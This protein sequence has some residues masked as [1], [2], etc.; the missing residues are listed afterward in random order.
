MK[1]L[2][3][4]LAVLALGLLPASA[5]M[6]LMT[7]AGVGSSGAS[8]SGLT[9]SAWLGFDD[10][11]SSAVDLS[12]DA[13]QLSAVSAG[14]L[15]VVG[16]GM[17][18]STLL[19]IEDDRANTYVVDQA[20]LP[21]M[22]HSVVTTGWTLASGDGILSTWAAATTNT[23]AGGWRVT[24]TLVSFSCG[25]ANATGTAVSVS[26]GGSVPT[27]TSVGFAVVMSPDAVTFSGPPAG[28]TED[29]D[30]QVG[31]DARAHYHGA[32]TATGVQTFTATA[33][34]STAWRAVVCVYW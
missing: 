4:L 21:G 28:W 27:S 8:P 34:V 20:T 17:L 18:G 26:T 33:S 12:F 5:Q 3:T 14:N 13:S 15:V 11:V 22:G 29:N 9:F 25:L 24:G 31:S 10:R 16:T 30:S 7:G 23:L 32:L 2:I 1:R 19:T 6:M